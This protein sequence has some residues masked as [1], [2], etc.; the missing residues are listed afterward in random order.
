MTMIKEERQVEAMLK[1]LEKQAHLDEA[2]TSEL[3]ETFGFQAAPSKP[4][5]FG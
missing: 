2:R 4:A 1:A 5:L 3:V